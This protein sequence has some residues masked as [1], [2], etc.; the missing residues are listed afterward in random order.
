VL[1]YIDWYKNV[2]I[3]NKIVP[4]ALFPWQQK[5]IMSENRRIAQTLPKLPSLTTSAL[6]PDQ[7][8]SFPCKPLITRQNTLPLIAP[9]QRP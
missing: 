8:E 4:R 1:N 7:R 9:D 6:A 3:V 2:T 5:K